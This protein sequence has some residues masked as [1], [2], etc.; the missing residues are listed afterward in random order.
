MPD[1]GLVVYLVA[2]AYA[3]GVVWYSLLGRTHANWMR[4][5]AFPLLGIVAGET[6]VS[7]GPVFFGLH[8]YVALASSLAAVFADVGIRW[9]G[10]QLTDSKIGHLTAKL[11]QTITGR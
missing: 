10:E 11:T 8:V 2:A 3:T 9:F 1:L 5:A 7:S 4:T 6:L